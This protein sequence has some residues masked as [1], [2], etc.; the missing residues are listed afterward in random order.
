[1]KYT[2]WK[3]VARPKKGQ[4]QQDQS[5]LKNKPKRQMLP[6]QKGMDPAAWEDWPA[7]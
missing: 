4:H 7:M 3:T 1:M 6:P 2:A 5:K